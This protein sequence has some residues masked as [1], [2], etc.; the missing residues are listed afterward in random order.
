MKILK[1]KR[2]GIIAYLFWIT[3]GIVIGIFAY[4]LF[5]G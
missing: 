2:G 4:K 3:I 5:F 1:D